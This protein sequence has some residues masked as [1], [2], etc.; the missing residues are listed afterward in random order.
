MSDVR[1][2]L[3]SFESLTGGC[4]RF[5]PRRFGFGRAR[6]FRDRDYVYITSAFGGCFGEVGRTGGPQVVNYQ[7]PGCTER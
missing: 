4:V 7:S 1:R 3:D 2:A 5:R 6:R